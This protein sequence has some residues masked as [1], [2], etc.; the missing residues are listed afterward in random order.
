[1]KTATITGF[2][3]IGWSG[4]IQPENRNNANM[5]D[6]IILSSMERAI[7][8]SCHHNFLISDVR[9]LENQ[10]PLT[11]QYYEDSLTYDMDKTAP[12]PF[13]N[14]DYYFPKKKSHRPTLRIKILPVFD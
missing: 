1:M 10:N 7:E 14:F 2:Q 3:L 8:Y 5:S 13:A 12:N 11:V 9:E 6:G 4:N